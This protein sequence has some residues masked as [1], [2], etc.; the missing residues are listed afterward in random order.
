MQNLLNILLTI[1]Y[2]KYIKSKN[3]FLKSFAN[4][5]SVY[6]SNV[7]KSFIR[8]RSSFSASTSLK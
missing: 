6:G 1:Y 4:F 3:H 8:V 7:N 2:T 5:A